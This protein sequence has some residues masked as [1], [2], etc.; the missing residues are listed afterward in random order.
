MDAVV[1]NDFVDNTKW[2]LFRHTEVHVPVA[3]IQTGR[4]GKGL[5]P[6]FRSSE[7]C[8]CADKVVFQQIKET[9]SHARLL[10][11]VRRTGNTR[12]PSVAINHPYRSANK[13]CLRKH[14]QQL[15]RIDKKIFMVDIII[16]DARHILAPNMLES[17]IDCRRGSH[18]LVRFNI[19]DPRVHN[20]ANY[21]FCAICRC[22]IEH[23]DLQWVLTVEMKDAFE[24]FEDVSLTII[25]INYYGD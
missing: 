1:C 8:R 17:K 13:G 12:R 6:T 22:I 23:N 7:D 25:D 15:H 5:L 18:I 4:H 3:E 14:F 16:V 20:T 21:G 11:I 2:G 19:L 24:T 9:I 10:P